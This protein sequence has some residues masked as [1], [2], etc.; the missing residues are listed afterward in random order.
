MRKRTHPLINLRRNLG[1]DINNDTW[2]KAICL[3]KLSSKENLLTDFQFGK[4][5]LEMILLKSQPSLYTRTLCKNL[6]LLCPRFLFLLFLLDIFSLVWIRLNT[7]QYWFKCFLFFFQYILFL[8]T[9]LPRSGHSLFLV[10]KTIIPVTHQIVSPVFTLNF[11]YMCW[12]LLY[13]YCNFL[14]RVL[15]YHELFWIDFKQFLPPY[16]DRSW[17]FFCLSL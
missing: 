1:K 6:S 9:P 16:L 7:Q 14:K 3:I 4:L 5:L 2:K 17:M 13:V 12:L 10:A 8:H 11:M 15:H